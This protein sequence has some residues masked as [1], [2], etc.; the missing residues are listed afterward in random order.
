VN[1]APYTI[2]E[3]EKREEN[4]G[5]QD[6]SNKLTFQTFSNFVTGNINNT[7]IQKPLNNPRKIRKSWRGGG[8]GRGGH[9][10]K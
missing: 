2:N 8:K 7:D 4:T 10:R 3:R 6:Y 9:Y 1:C 5:L